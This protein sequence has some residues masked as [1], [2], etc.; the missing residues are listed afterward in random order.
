MLAGQQ[1]EL[2]DATG[3]VLATAVT[4]AAGYFVF[5]KLKDGE[6]QVRV[7]QTI[8]DQKLV[9]GPN[10]P[11]P[12]MSVQVRTEHNAHVGYFGYR[13]DGPAVTEIVTSSPSPS[14]TETL[15][16]VVIP[17]E[18]GTTTVITTTAA[19]PA[20]S[21]P[22]PVPVPVPTTPSASAQPGSAG[23]NAPGEQ[24]VVSDGKTGALAKTGASVIGIVGAA[25]LLV[26]LG[27]FLVKRRK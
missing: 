9:S 25:T 22:V 27:L 16:P 4:D 2:L 14:T 11:N 19:V 24:R 1:V 21:A 26:L 13:A 5:P 6:Y 10:G 18:P 17:S 12:V 20:Q 7:Q 23:K 15:P 8:G 3:A